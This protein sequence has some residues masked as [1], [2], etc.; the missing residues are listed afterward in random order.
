MQ[1]RSN[2]QN[3]VESNKFAKLSSILVICLKFVVIEMLDICIT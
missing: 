2:S 3:K 1:K